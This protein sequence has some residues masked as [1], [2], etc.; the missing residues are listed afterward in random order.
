M[1]FCMRVVGAVSKNADSIVDGRFVEL[2]FGGT[3]L[4]GMWC[5]AIRVGGVWVECSVHGEGEYD[6]RSAM[7]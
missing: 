5:G 7:N 1:D 4:W 2:H 3:V 6:T